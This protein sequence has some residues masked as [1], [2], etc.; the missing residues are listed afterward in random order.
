M[1]DQ[2]RERALD[3]ALAELSPGHRAV[4][5]LRVRGEMDIATIAHVLGIPEGTVKSRIHNAVLR[6]RSST[7]RMGGRDDR[8][9]TP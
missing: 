7:D 6:M 4:L 2:R 3:A 8:G 5:L 1:D 9:G